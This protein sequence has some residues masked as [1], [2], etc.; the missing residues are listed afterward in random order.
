MKN[1]EIIKKRTQ[2]VTP[3]MLI[4]AYIFLNSISLN[5][6]SLIYKDK[7]IHLRKVMKNYTWISNCL[8][9]INLLLSGIFHKF[10]EASY[11]Y[12]D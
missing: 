7:Y 8:H 3:K 5:E 4:R 6:S 9:H 1:R 10:F 12:I 2:E 11:V